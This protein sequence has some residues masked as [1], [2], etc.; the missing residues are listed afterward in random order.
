MPSNFCHLFFGLQVMFSGCSKQQ[1]NCWHEMLLYHPLVDKLPSLLTMTLARLDQP[2][3]FL[4]QPGCHSKLPACQSASLPSCCHVA[5]T[6]PGPCLGLTSQACLVA[7]ACL[8]HQS[9]HFYPVH[10]SK[11][12]QRCWVLNRDKS[13]ENGYLYNPNLVEFC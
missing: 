12:C 6:L 1:C 4:I 10:I 11:F 9:F 8:S 13:N 7:W 3:P 2:E 5:C